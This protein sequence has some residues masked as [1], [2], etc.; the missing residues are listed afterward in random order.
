MYKDHAR[1]N[2]LSGRSFLSTIV[3][4]NV[5]VGQKLKPVREGRYI[6]VTAFQHC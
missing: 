6:K 3:T 4:V 5:V 2:I 1:S